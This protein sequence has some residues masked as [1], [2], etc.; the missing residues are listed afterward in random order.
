MGHAIE[1]AR[2]VNFATLEIFA[3][4]C[5]VGR[6]NF[7]VRPEGL[8]SVTEAELPPLLLLPGCF[9]IK[10]MQ[11]ELAVTIRFCI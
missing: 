5:R 10:T 4:C 3:I 1:V 2:G 7:H 11:G 6:P 8:T 9:A